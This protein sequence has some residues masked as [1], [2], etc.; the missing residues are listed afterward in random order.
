MHPLPSPNELLDDIEGPWMDELRRI[1]PTA[2]TSQKRILSIGTP[3]VH[4]LRVSSE[5]GATWI[6]AARN[7]VWLCAVHKREADSDDDAFSYFGELHGQGRLLPDRD[8]ALRLAA[9]EAVYAHTQ[10]TKALM[11]LFEVALNEPGKTQEAALC[12]LV[13]CRLVATQGNGL[14][15]VWCSL[16]LQTTSGEFIN[17][18]R[19]EYLFAEL[20]RRCAPSVVEIQDCWIDG[21]EVPWFESV[22]LLIRES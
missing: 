16:C 3:M 1:A 9:E 17:E 14:Q 7:V 6:D 21:E 13:P 2:P 5:R 11:E 10:L 8:D 18:K 20:E 15:E 12:D 22:R 4:R 19:R